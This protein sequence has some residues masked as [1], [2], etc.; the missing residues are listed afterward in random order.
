MD[1]FTYTLKGADYALVDAVI[2]LPILTH[3]GLFKCIEVKKKM[4]TINGQQRPGIKCDFIDYKAGFW[5]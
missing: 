3:W 5:V 2:W 4:P 1:I